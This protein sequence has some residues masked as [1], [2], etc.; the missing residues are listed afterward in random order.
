MMRY[1]RSIILLAPA[2][3]LISGFSVP[4]PRPQEIPLVFKSEVRIVE[5]HALVKDNHGRFVEGL[6]PEQFEVRDNGEPQPIATFEPMATGFDCAILL[7]CTGSMEKALPALKGAV[8]RLIDAFRDQDRFA[9]YTFDTTLRRLQDYSAD[10]TAA[11]QAVLRILPG[12]GTALFDSLHAV[13]AELAERKGKKAIIAFTD[14]QDNSSYLH[15]MS[16]MTRAKALG[17]PIYAVAQGEA[18][19]D[20]Y[21]FRMLKEIG[22][23]T[24]G[25]AYEVR[26]PSQVSW[27]FAEI[28]DDIRHAYLLT[29]AAPPAGNDR[30]RTIQVILKGAK[31]VQIRA[32]GG[33]FPR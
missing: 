2:V 22:Q 32:R 11:K 3:L 33:Y 31:A 26:K 10:K 28:C 20:Q 16:V 9:V 13:A 6:Q 14:G 4:I 18:L 25:G 12:G 17:L 23:A 27:V 1:I 21:L 19:S 15:S 8:L 30:W 24:G 29:Y 7:D 5:V